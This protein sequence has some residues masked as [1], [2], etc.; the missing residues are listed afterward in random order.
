MEEQAEMPLLTKKKKTTQGSCT[1]SP[2]QAPLAKAAECCAPGHALVMYM[3]E[4]FVH[5]N[6]NTQQE[7]IVKVKRTEPEGREHAL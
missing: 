1:G 5:M 6:E 4:Q 7:P 3:P 2:S